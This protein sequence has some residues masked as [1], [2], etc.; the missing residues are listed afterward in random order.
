VKQLFT[1]SKGNTHVTEQIII[2]VEE[3]FNEVIF[4]EPG[5]SLLHLHLHLPNSSSMYMHHLAYALYHRDLR[6]QNFALQCVQLFSPSL[7]C[8]D[9]PSAWIFPYEEKKMGDVKFANWRAQKIIKE[10]DGL[11]DICIPNNQQDKRNDWKHTVSL[12]HN[13]I[14]L[15]QFCNQFNDAAIDEFQ[16]M[17]NDFFSAWLSLQGYDGI[18]NYIHMLGAGHIRYY[19]Q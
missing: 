8:T 9:C 4:G 3:Y 18:T 1:V 15:L 7:S 5:K 2:Q 16:N 14:E 12:Y 11:V 19:L 17:A 13:T 6:S 10:I